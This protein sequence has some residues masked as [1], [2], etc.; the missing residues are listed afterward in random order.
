LEPVGAEA[1]LVQLGD[2]QG[3][4]AHLGRQHPLAGAIAVGGALIG[5]SLMEL[6]VGQGRNLSLQQVLEASAQDFRDQGAEGGA[7]HELSHLGGATTGE[8]PW[9]VFGW[10]VAL[11]T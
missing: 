2:D 5:A 9:S 10:V 11:R 1:A 3:E 7:L 6:G 8:G 4:V